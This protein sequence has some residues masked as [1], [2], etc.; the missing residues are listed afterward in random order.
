MSILTNLNG[1]RMSIKCKSKN[2]GG[3]TDYYKLPAGATELQDLIEYK[4]MS[5]SVGNIF[6][7]CYRL[8]NCEHSDRVRDLN[9]IIWFAQRELNKEGNNE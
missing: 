9:K 2:N 7:S 6:K 8:G 4:D 3:S 5:F 1:E